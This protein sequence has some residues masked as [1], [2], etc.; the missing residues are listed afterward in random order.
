[1]KISNGVKI[2][3]DS[4]KIKEI[5]ERGIEQVID[6]KNLL[7]KLKSG[8][9]LRI[10]LGIDPTGPKIHLGRAIQLW[11]LRNFQ[12]LGH[13]IVFIIGD[14]TGQIGD[15]S[16]KQ[17]MRKPLTEEEIKENLRTYKKQIGKI[18]DLKK[19]EFHRN[20]EWLSKLKIKDFLSLAMSFTAQQMIQRRNFRERWEQNKPIGL[21]ELSYPLLQGYDSVMIKADVEIGGFDQLFNLKM[22]REMQRIFGQPPQ[23]IMTSQ[24]LYGLDGR[25]MSTS[26]GNVINITDNPRNMYGKIMSMKDELIED[27]LKLTTRFPLKKIEKIKKDLKEEKLNPKEAKSILAKEIIKMYHSKKAGETAEKEF[28]RVFRE[29]KLPLK[30][31]VFKSSKKSLPILDLLTKANLASSKNEAKRLILQGGVSIRIKNQELRIKDWR[32][33]IKLKNGMILQVGK[34]KFLKI[35]LV[36]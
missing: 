4:K 15:A 10:K 31:P 30:I 23:D 1:M 8:K 33:D 7:K 16:D 27:Y 3:T 6:K 19:V 36:K 29:K 20:S 26:W 17:A 24:M 14:F 9:K 2:N 11:K 5:L 34:R 25:K 12:D 18:L 35:R 32:Q 21:H 13:Q 28:N 22:G